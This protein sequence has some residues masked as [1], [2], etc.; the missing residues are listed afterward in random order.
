MRFRLFLCVALCMI[1]LVAACQGPPPTQIVM[2][3]TQ[4]VTVLPNETSQVQS[5]STQQPS[6]AV[7]T[8]TPLVPTSTPAAAPTT[9]PAPTPITAQIQ[10]AEQVFEHGRMFW[11]QPRKQIWVMIESSPDKGKWSVYEDTFVDGEQESDPSLIPPAGLYQPQRGFGKLW[12]TTPG[13]RDAL[14]W[15]KTPEFG[16]VSN[17][18]YRVNG[19]INVQG[20][21]VPQQSYHILFSLAHEEFRF[22]EGDSTWQK[23]G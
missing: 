10:L 20:T 13:L 14:G 23:T 18:E 1:T 9:N 21:F 7:P 8:Q 17:Y 11:I 6:A 19:Q 15:G 16:Y 5:D 3:I 12:R 2:V 22:N 4:V